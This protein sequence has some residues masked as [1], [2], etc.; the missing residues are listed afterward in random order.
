[1]PQT[2]KPCKLVVPDIGA[3]AVR[4]HDVPTC[5][6]E[7]WKSVACSFG[8]LPLFTFPSGRPLLIGKAGDTHV[9]LETDCDVQRWLESVRNLGEFEVPH[10]LLSNAVLTAQA[11]LESQKNKE[12]ET[13][14][15]K[16]Q[17]VCEL[18]AAYLL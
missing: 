3:T 16:L 13:Q 12:L 8:R 11:L 2:R 17:E 6:A 14:V 9:V 10:I 18:L 1:M 7:I 15:Q 5:L 4:L